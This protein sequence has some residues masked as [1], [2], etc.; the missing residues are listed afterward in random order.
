MHPLQN[1]K[2]GAV[3]GSGHGKTDACLFF[4]SVRTVQSD[5]LT[6]FPPTTYGTNPLSA[7]CLVGMLQG[8]HFPWVQIRDFSSN[9]HCQEVQTI[10]QVSC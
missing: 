3:A 10:S 6:I 8:N 4:F 5:E 9:L 7:L 1:T 2:S